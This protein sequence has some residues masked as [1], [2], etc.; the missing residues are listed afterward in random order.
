M[1]GNN[2]YRPY[3]N[4]N[5]RPVTRIWYRTEKEATETAKA[6]TQEPF[7]VVSRDVNLLVKNRRKTGFR[8]LI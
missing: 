8:G 5:K 6:F 2:L 4:K 1:I 3:Y 7:N